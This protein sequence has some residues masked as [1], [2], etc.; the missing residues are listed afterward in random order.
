MRA[1]SAGKCGSVNGRS[2]LPGSMPDNS[3]KSTSPPACPSCGAV[4][5]VK[6]ERTIKG[7]SITLTVA[8]RPL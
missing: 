3:I 8:L 4:G 2:D 5:T 7:A 1:A 6:Q